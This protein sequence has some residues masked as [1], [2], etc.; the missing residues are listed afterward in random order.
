MK[1]YKFKSGKVVTYEE[2]REWW[3]W[4]NPHYCHDDVEFAMSLAVD[5][6]NGTLTEVDG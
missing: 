4:C 1:K 6:A 5:I 2:L 3:N